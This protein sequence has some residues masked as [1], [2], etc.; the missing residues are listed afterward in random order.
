[1]HPARITGILYLTI[2]AC[3]IFAEAVVRASLVVADDPAATEHSLWVWPAD[4]IE[5]DAV[6]LPEGFGTL[7][8]DPTGATMTLP[9][10]RLQNDD[11]A[12]WVVSEKA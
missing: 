11:P 3:G 8:P 7:W 5:P 6:P 2:I 9:D 4:A 12:N 1:M 10:P